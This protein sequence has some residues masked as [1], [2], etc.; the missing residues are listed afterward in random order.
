MVGSPTTTTAA[1][2]GTS[3]GFPRGPLL[4]SDVLL[5]IC[6]HLV[7]NNQDILSLAL[8]CRT[9]SQL[10]L[11][12]LWRHATFILAGGKLWTCPS[13][14]STPRKQ[15]PKYIK[16]Q[17]TQEWLSTLG[18][19]YLP[20]IHNL[21]L[22]LCL[23]TQYFPRSP[24]LIFPIV[25]K[26]IEGFFAVLDQARNLRHLVLYFHFERPIADVIFEGIDSMWADDLIPVVTRFT[27]QDSPPPS[28]SS[29]ASTTTGPE[30]KEKKFRALKSLTLNRGR[31][32]FGA[33]EQLAFPYIVRRAP[34][35]ER[36]LVTGLTGWSSQLR[37]TVA[38]ASFENGFLHTLDIQEGDSKPI[39]NLDLSTIRHVKLTAPDQVSAFCLR[40][41]LSLESVEFVCKGPSDGFEG[42]VDALLDVLAS[43]VSLVNA[44]AAAATAQ[45]GFSS[46]P[47]IQSG[48]LKAFKLKPHQDY[49]GSLNSHLPPLIRFL[50]NRNVGFELRILKLGFY[51]ADVLN[52]IKMGRLCPNLGAL[53]LGTT[54]TGRISVPAINDQGHFLHTGLDIPQW[55]AW[56]W[57]FPAVLKLVVEAT[58]HM[59][60]L[61]TLS[62]KMLELYRRQDMM[63]LVPSI[64]RHMP[65]LRK[66]ILKGHVRFSLSEEDCERLV[67][68]IR[69][70]YPQM[71]VVTVDLR[72][73]DWEKEVEV[74]RRQMPVQ[75]ADWPDWLPAIPA[76]NVF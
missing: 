9:L 32:C 18:K 66:L 3:S 7:P 29:S 22:R 50:N 45:V 61:Q 75:M 34:N 60:H 64:P 10:A 71:D 36:F 21:E 31:T 6:E 25:E 44:A 23:T 47:P 73:R 17:D 37:S 58:V 1:I 48:R 69:D 8:T 62:L 35:L 46:T 19:R 14:A 11:P 40:S 53:Y 5:M 74:M 16:H 54:K 28:P 15:K 42:T 56:P 2:T 55:D 70:L 30:A 43:R 41:M 27:H 67:G 13:L 52:A 68:R 49:K 51:S 39:H 38:Q 65:S 63:D 26:D 24:K 12:L 76:M 4:S 59:T 57:A 33:A 72:E 20:Y